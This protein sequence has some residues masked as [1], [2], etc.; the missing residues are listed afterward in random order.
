MS[1][2][3][4]RNDIGENIDTSNV[5]APH[6]SPY[7]NDSSYNIID[8]SQNIH[9]HLLDIS[10]RQKLPDLDKSICSIGISCDLSMV[11]KNSINIKK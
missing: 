1:T 2:R 4:N 8:L 9:F 11:D 6:Y 3:E 7:R 10:N 5:S